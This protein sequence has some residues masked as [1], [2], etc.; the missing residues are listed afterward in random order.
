M[1]E[2]K[3][4]RVTFSHSMLSTYRR[5]RFKFD[6]SYRQAYIAP[7]SPGQF[8][9]SA[10]HKA[11]EV[12]YA[13]D[14]NIQMAVQKAW[15]YWFEKLGD[16]PPEEDWAMLETALYRYGKW[17][18]QND[19]FEVISTE[20]HFDIPLTENYSLQGYIDG[21]VKVGKG[22]WLLEHKFNKRVSTKH[23][24]L[25][26]Q[27]SVYMLAAAL[28]GLEPQGVFYNIVRMGDGPTADREPVVRTMV[29]RN[30]EGL[31]FFMDE[32]VELMEEVDNFLKGK[33][34]VYRNMNADC[35]WDCPFTSVCL[36]INDV[37]SAESVLNTFQKGV[38]FDERSD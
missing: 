9:G 28:L 33:G 31:S 23:L 27:V 12:Y 3:I 17:A 5:C 1:A 30:P 21:V 36:S 13:N 6:L 26:P 8:R 10:G 29:Y 22:I 32:T 25:D 16:V 37:G 4:E 15:D 11:L 34:A 19:K 35:S 24:D 7:S 20:F 38:P 18:A 2:D 14:R